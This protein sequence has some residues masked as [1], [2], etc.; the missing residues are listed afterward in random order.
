G[1]GVGQATVRLVPTRAEDISS[2]YLTTSPSDA[3]DFLSQYDVRYVVVGEL[4]KL[5][6]ESF[7]KCQPIDGGG[8]VTCD[9][10][11]RFVGQRTLDVPASQ[12]ETLG[13]ALAC[14]TGGLEKFEAM[15]S[16]GILRAVYRNGSTTIYE[17]LT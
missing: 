4:E 1:E 10:S 6:Y 8:R 3:I 5:Y 16:L 2:F 17:V 9:M 14:P 12:C 11:G 7:D 15:E 13:S